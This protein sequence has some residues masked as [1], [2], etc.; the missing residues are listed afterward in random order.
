MRKK[1]VIRKACLDD[2]D[3]IITVEEL[4]WPEG[5]RADSD[6]YMSRIN[7]FNDGVICAEVER[8]IEGVVVTEIVQYDLK[9]PI[10][11]WGEV[12]D[13]GFITK[14]H[15]PDGDTLYGVSLSVLPYANGGISKK[16]LI[17]AGQ[18]AVHKNLKQI[19]LGARIPRYRKY[20]KAM[21]AIN[22]AYSRTKTGKFLD[23][24]LEFYSKYGLEIV[25]VLPDYFPDPDSLNYG[26]LLVWR[27]YLYN[28]PLRRV[29]AKFLR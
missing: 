15:N 19:V 2:L 16:L 21:P 11:T 27:N 23:P 20:S 29:L 7:T 28:H 5:M 24:E 17:A 25:T 8:R 18:L 14:T 9:N 22:Y 10:K 3:E 13:S 4:S 6:K 26:V 12:T 1:I